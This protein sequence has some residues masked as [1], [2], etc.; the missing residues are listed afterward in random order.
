VTV[1]AGRVAFMGKLSLKNSFG[2]GDADAT[3]MHYAN[4]IFRPEIIGSV[5][6]LGG[7]LM[8]RLDGAARDA[9]TEKAF[10]TRAAEKAFRRDRAWQDVIRK[11]QLPP[12]GLTALA[13]D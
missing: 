13:F 2:V 1:E 5:A 9:E 7:S 6:N 4:E 8:S 3:Q 12:A 10:W 11:K